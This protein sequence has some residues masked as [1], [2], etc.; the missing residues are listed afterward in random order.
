MMDSVPNFYH[1]PNQCYAEAPSI[2]GKYRTRRN[3][4]KDKKETEALYTEDN[5]ETG[6]RWENS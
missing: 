2:Q 1:V 4:T 6:N 3:T 5:M